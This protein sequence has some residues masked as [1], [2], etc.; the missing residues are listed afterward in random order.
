M[1]EALS[2][3]PVNDAFSRWQAAAGLSF[4]ESERLIATAVYDQ[5]LADKRRHDAEE[6]RRRNPFRSS[7]ELP[8]IDPGWRD[9]ARAHEARRA[10]DLRD[11]QHALENIER[12]VH[13]QR[14]AVDSADTQ[15]RHFTSPNYLWLGIGVLCVLATAGMALPVWFLPQSPTEF[16]SEQN[17]LILI[18]FFGAVGLVIAYLAFLAGML[19]YRKLAPPMYPR[20]YGEGIRPSG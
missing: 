9:D 8:Y 7:L 13:D 6:E 4:S 16:T 14:V 18:A 11:K 1:T 20:E 10:A 15:I 12:D 17:A 5:E 2:W 3:H 19:A